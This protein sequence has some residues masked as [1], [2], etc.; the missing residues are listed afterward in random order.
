MIKKIIPLSLFHYNYYHYHYHYNNYHYHHLY[1]HYY[2]HLYYYYFHMYLFMAFVVYYYL[3]CHFLCREWNSFTLSCFCLT[4]SKYCL[5]R[6]CHD[7][8]FNGFFAI[9]IF[10][11]NCLFPSICVRNFFLFFFFFY[12]VTQ[13]FAF[14]LAVCF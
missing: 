3:P 14:F 7:L 13:F 2:H 6:Q 4:L 5:W 12:L 11:D 9:V 1:Y 10:T 8:E